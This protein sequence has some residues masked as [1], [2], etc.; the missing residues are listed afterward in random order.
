MKNNILL[1]VILL[2]LFSCEQNEKAM[3]PEFSPSNVQNDPSCIFES[4]ICLGS[5]FEEVEL[6]YPDMIPQGE[7]DYYQ[8]IIWDQKYSRD[9]TSKVIAMDRA[10]HLHFDEQNILEEYAVNFL[11]FHG[12]YSP[13]TDFWYEFV[14]ALGADQLTHYKIEN[15][16][17]E[18]PWRYTDSIADPA[19]LKIVHN[20]NVHDIIRINI[21]VS[22]EG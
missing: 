8:Y 1:F 21:K 9:K 20:F 18:R 4:T 3:S 2:A 22:N 15:P 14:K 13:K 12:Q 10:I 11:H 17:I 19:G 5:I 7:E 16:E 6:V